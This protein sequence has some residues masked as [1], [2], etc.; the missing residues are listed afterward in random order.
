MKLEFCLEVL[1]RF[2]AVFLFLLLTSCVPDA[3]FSGNNKV[4]FVSEFTGFFP[5]DSQNQVLPVWKGSLED[6]EPVVLGAIKSFDVQFQ[7]VFSFDIT[8]LRNG[9]RVHELRGSGLVKN[10]LQI[11]VSETLEH[12]AVGVFDMAVAYPN[13][14]P[15]NSVGAKLEAAIATALDAKFVRDRF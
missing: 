1:M 6:L 10:N 3:N 5:Q 2:F 8:T 7:G 11:V 13:I 15:P 12:V 4:N 9:L 14:A